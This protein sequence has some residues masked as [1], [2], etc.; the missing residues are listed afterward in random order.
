MLRLSNRDLS[1][2]ILDPNDA[3]DNKRQGWRYCHGGYVWQVTDAQLGPLL[4]GPSYPAEPTVYDGQGLP[5]SFRHTR[6][7]NNA[8]LTWKGDAG[9]A[10]GAGNITA[11]PDPKA[12]AADSVRLGE[13]CQWTVTKAPDHLIFQTRQTAA[14]LS[15]EL[16]RKIELAGRTVTSFTQLTNV[17]DTPLALQWF[18]HPFWALT[19]QRAQIKLPAGTTV[20]DNGVFTIAADGSL[21]FKRPFGPKPDNQ[22]ALLTLPPKTPLALSLNHPK[23]KRVTFEASYVPFDCPI[24]G[25]GHTISVEPYLG[26]TI[27]PG[28]TRLWFAKHGFEK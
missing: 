27:P 2:D 25:N 19:E 1:L 22:F 21:T 5:E 10:I 11:N 14:G 3:A 16:S 15:Y 4:T 9:H 23:L 20:P 12:G 6:R 13:P 24:W 8:R 7:D 17:G 28:E 26:L 18:P